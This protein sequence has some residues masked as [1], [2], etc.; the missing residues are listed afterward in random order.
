MNTVGPRLMLGFGSGGGMGALLE[1][2][3]LV[4]EC[5]LYLAVIAISAP[6][7]ADEASQEAEEHHHPDT[8]ARCDVRVKS[9]TRRHPR[10]GRRRRRRRRR[11]H[12]DVGEWFQCEQASFHLRSDP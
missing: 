4:V 2:A 6:D 10:G 11:G 9:L 5:P 12:G 7:A 1:G 8:D 3:L